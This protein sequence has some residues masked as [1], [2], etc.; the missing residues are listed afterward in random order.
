LTNAFSK[1]PDNFKVAVALDFPYYD[2]VKAHGALK[3]TPAMA[4]RPLRVTMAVWVR[5]RK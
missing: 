1:K 3:M 2:F 4:G 5:P